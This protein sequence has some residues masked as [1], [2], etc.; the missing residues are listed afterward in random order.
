MLS[1]VIFGAGQYLL[2]Q[3]P[4][5][6]VDDTEV[7]CVYSYREKD[8]STGEDK[9]KFFLCVKENSGSKG[10]SYKLKEEGGLALRFDDKRAII[11][12]SY[13]ST[14][15]SFTLEAVDFSG[16]AQEK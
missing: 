5:V 7:L 3:A 16:D 13:P 12:Q 15:G 9:Q 8:E 6:T 14:T 4:L 1:F 2:C 11:S 10:Y